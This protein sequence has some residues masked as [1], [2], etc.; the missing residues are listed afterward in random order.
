MN[1]EEPRGAS[2]PSEA[3]TT[4]PTAVRKQWHTPVLSLFEAAEAEHN[5]FST[6]FDLGHNTKTGGSS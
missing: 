3:I 4:A 2:A 6:K 1:S 5:K